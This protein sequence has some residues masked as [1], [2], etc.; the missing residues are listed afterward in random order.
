[1]DSNTDDTI[2]PLLYEGGSEWYCNVLA[3][4]HIQCHSHVDRGEY[5]EAFSLERFGDRVDRGVVIE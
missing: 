3:A 4:G 5:S 2:I 1:L